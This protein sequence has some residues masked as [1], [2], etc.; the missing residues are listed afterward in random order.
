M[1]IEERQAGD[2]LEL[3]ISGRLDATWAEHL[4]ALVAQAVR[5]GSLRIAAD[6]TGVSYISSAGIG[7][8]VK[9]YQELGTL[10]GAFWIAKY[11]DA[12][13][14]ILDVV[15]LLATL[16]APPET[17][18]PHGRTVE[19]ESASLRVTELVP[20]APMRGRRHGRPELLDGCRFEAGDAER[21]S[22]ADLALLVGVGAFGDSFQ[23]AR[24]RCGE[25]LAV[26]GSAVYLPTDGSGVPDFL[27]AAGGFVP[28]VELLYGLSAAGPFP[29][30]AMFESRKGLSVPLHELAEAALTLVGSGPAALVVVGE[31]SALVGAALRRSPGAGPAAGAPF[32]FPEMRRWISLTSESGGARRAL[33][34]CGVVAR[35]AEA[36]NLL[37]FLRPMEAGTGVLAHLHGAGFSVR[38]SAQRTHELS[39]AVQGL[40]EGG[41]VRS[42]LHLL[43]DEREGE[44]EL[45]RGTLWCGPLE[46][47]G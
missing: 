18:A 39:A 31:P 27:L 37:P 43:A 45:L 35:E 34:A 26:G 33:L 24:A 40:F 46:M 25:L 29:L 12:V 7:I 19:T 11:S 21:V 32:G 23:E 36:A 9:A 38:Q 42:V 6:L 4:D 41:T 5:R 16:T 1:E 30:A 22:L 28:E 10:Q 14:R 8:L 2:V 13:A 15:G 3:R 44:T 47:Q 17:A 20:L